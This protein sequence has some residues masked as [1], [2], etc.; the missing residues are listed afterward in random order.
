MK[1]A[2]ISDSERNCYFCKWAENSGFHICYSLPNHKSRQWTCTYNP[3]WVDIFTD[4][5]PPLNMVVRHY[6]SKYERKTQ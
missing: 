6:C 5:D 1:E 4:Y 2:P 3:V